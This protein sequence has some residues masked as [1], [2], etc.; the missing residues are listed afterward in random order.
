MAK[1]KRKAKPGPA[2]QAV[3]E[4]QATRQW[5]ALGLLVVIAL[6]GFL[7]WVLAPGRGGE[8]VAVRVPALSV[9]AQQG[10]GAFQKNCAACHGSNAGGTDQGPPLIHTIYR[11][12]HHGDGA[13]LRAMLMGVRAHH[14]PFGNMPP[15]RQV[16][17]ED[18]TAI[19][20]YLR[21]VQRANGIR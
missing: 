2:K 13:I 15:Q 11:P 19:V 12:G 14:W 10:Q 16:A 3:K 21:E 17:R 1:G 9:S 8:T 4:K 20:A 6:G 5:V 18:A 7:W